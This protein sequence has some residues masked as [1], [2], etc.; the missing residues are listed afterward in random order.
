MA[1]T[2][3]IT[4][5]TTSSLTDIQI[6][7]ANKTMGPSQLST[8]LSV[9]HISESNCAGALAPTTTSQNQDSVA[10]AISFNTPEN[11]PF[12]MDPSGK[13][14]LSGQTVEP[15]S[16]YSREVSPSEKSSGDA[17]D[18]KTV[19][20]DAG[21][22]IKVE[23]QSI[24]LSC[25]VSVKP[26]SKPHLNHEKDE[27]STSSIITK[28]EVSLSTNS[29]SINTI[30]AAS[31]RP[32]KVGNSTT[33][34]V[35][36]S[37][38]AKNTPKRAS[39]P[40]GRNITFTPQPQSQQQKK[41]MRS[42]SPKRCTSDL[43]SFEDTKLGDG[44]LLSPYLPSPPATKGETG[45]TNGAQK[46]KDRSG[47]ITPTNF[48]ADFGKTDLSSSSFDAN[49]VLSWLSPNAYSL[50][51]PG[52]GLH[53]TANTP[54]GARTPRTPTLNSIFFNE[55]ELAANHLPS[56]NPSNE[57]DS[58]PPKNSV[59]DQNK[60]GIQHPYSSMICVSPLAS[61]KRNVPAKPGDK[62][63]VVD[64]NIPGT[65]INIADVF[66]S[67][68]VN[69]KT[70]MKSEKSNELPT[71][72]PQHLSPTDK[73][74]IEKHMAER[75]LMEDEDLSV[76]LQ[77][78]QTTPRRVSSA[79]GNGD[80][81]LGTRVFRSSPRHKMQFAP[82]S[83]RPPSNLQLP[84]IGHRGHEQSSS[85]SYRKKQGKDMAGHPDDFTPPPLAIRSCSSNGS[86]ELR[87]TPGSR[88]GKG[89]MSKKDETGT[90]PNQ[91]HPFPRNGSSGSKSSLSTNVY[92]TP[93]PPPPP[94]FGNP[95]PP[96]MHHPPH[97]MYPHPPHVPNVHMPHP[98]APPYHYS[99]PPSH[100]P[101]PHP[102]SMYSNAPVP[103]QQSKTTPKKGQKQK[104]VGK[105]SNTN[106]RSPL[107][108]AGNSVKKSKKSNGTKPKGS[109]S[110]RS[111][112]SPSVNLNNPVDRQKAAAAISAMNVASGSKN[113]K[114]AALASAILRGVT[115]RPS[116]KWQAQ[117][118]YAGK[119]RYI[120][121]FDTREKAALAYEIAR[122]KL[123]TDRSP[124]EQGALTIKETEANVNA[125]RKAAF[126]GVN[127]KD[128]RLAAK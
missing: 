26:G 27:V 20:E 60:Q 19:T 82:N 99:Y 102:Y 9:Q 33:R 34:S 84:L 86:R 50:F 91:N 90:P 59:T 85:H 76:L 44:V 5:S 64:S 56:L 72:R 11:S 36:N 94:Q 63:C 120:G 123:K 8:S 66:A 47:G 48:A 17:A 41:T 24:A 31:S 101:P 4:R 126:E 79:G 18:G 32:M 42:C 65:P 125:A 96:H 81:K 52:G 12:P 124:S 118:Y 98:P 22:T 128:P 39:V 6:D 21:P 16:E 117:L 69:S 55:Q 54:R 61:S 83:N 75:D 110:K 127:E 100:P 112:S 73:L 23:D 3:F 108:V 62:Q 15:K 37:L 95:M 103:S 1:S 13:K 29:D 35:E 93:A 14:G 122:E 77:L 40:T 58:K 115:M 89:K 114:A 67:P 121:V 107:T 2:I 104:T 10:T 97:G 71:L 57:T 106:K 92:N 111:K 25:T 46:E 7:Q 49:N 28:G 30:D 70:G 74:S 45:K 38:I 113:D 78:A 51:S 116:G 88:K 80:P 109:G 87:S 119:S 53:S 43:P 68:K 105:A